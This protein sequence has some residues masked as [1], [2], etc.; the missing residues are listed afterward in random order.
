MSNLSHQS[1]LARV[2]ICMIRFY[3]TNRISS[4]PRCRFVPT[5]SEYMISAIQYFGVWRGLLKGCWRILRC[6]PFSRGGFD[7][8]IPNAGATTEE[9][10]EM[11]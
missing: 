7:P 6:H 8:V 10:G 11:E 1:R 9:N 4:V 3:Q 5:C 2:F